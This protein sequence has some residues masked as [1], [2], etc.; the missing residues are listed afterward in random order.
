M[1]QTLECV[2]NYSSDTN[3]KN[4]QKYFIINVFISKDFYS[5]WHTYVSLVGKKK[6]Y[7]YKKKSNVKV[8]F[9]N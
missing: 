9:T 1:H 8:S 7:V 4:D 5:P 3:K 6:N 2:F